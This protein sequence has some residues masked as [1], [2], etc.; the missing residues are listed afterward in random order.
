MKTCKQDIKETKEAIERLQ[1]DEAISFNLQDIVDIEDVDIDT[2]L[3]HGK[4]IFPVF[5]KKFEKVKEL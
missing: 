4:T 5:H 1:D 3:L 2:L